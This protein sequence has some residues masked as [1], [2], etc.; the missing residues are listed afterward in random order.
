M[1][2]DTTF[3]YKKATSF[4]P[5][6]FDDLMTDSAKATFVMDGEENVNTSGLTNPVVEWQTRVASQTGGEIFQ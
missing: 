4:C 3:I 6:A 1:K 5:P 2:V